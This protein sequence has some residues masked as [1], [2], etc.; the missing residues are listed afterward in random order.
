MEFEKKYLFENNIGKSKLITKSSIEIIIAIFYF[1]NP[2]FISKSK[3]KQLTLNFHYNVTV[4]ILV[5]KENSTWFNYTTQHN[6]LQNV[7]LISK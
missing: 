4:D 2:H 5:W 7:K 6:I 1:R 3:T